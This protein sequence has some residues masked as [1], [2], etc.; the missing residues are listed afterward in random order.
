LTISSRYCL[1]SPMCTFTMTTYVG[2]YAHAAHPKI[3]CL[4]RTRCAVVAPRFKFPCQKNRSCTNFKVPI[5][6]D[7]FLLLGRRIGENSQI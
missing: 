6:V 7:F 3:F 5:V 4:A 2:T 1:F